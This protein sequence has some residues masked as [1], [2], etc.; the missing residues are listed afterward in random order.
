MVLSQKTQ[1]AVRAVLE[2]ARK[3]G[4]G[5][6][7]AAKIA[8]VQSIPLRFLENILGQLRQAGLVESVRGKEGGYL[9]SRSPHEVTV[10]D[11]VRLVQG[12]VSVVNCAETEAERSC[13]LRQNCV[14]LPLWER[15]HAAMMEVYDGSTLEDLVEQERLLTEC[16]A[17]DYAI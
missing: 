5:P 17:A 11:V 13:A 1:Y 6:V 9:L 15:A 2:L 14:L 3:N 12:P 16:E 4:F 8:S 7:K 10:G